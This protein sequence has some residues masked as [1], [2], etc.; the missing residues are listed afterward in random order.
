[1]LPL[2]TPAE[3]S[4]DRATQTGTGAA[5]P[6]KSPQRRLFPHLRPE[7]PTFS[8]GTGDF[9]G[10]NQL[11]L[12]PLR[13]EVHLS[14]EGAPVGRTRTELL[15]NVRA[16]PPQHGAQQQRS[17]RV[18]HQSAPASPSAA[19]PISAAAAR[20]FRELSRKVRLTQI[21][22]PDNVPIFS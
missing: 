11:P 18:S 5:F 4:A 10:G 17:R 15:S 12:L 21:H 2:Q 6:G 16:Y 3:T 13:P 1:M 22:P 8:G 7:H 14:R 20:K 19:S 9:G